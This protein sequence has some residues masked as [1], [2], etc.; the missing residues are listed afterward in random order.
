MQRSETCY[1]ENAVRKKGRK[2]KMKTK[3]CRQLTWGKQVA[4]TSSQSL[5]LPKAIRTL[6]RSG[7]LGD[8]KLRAK[9]IFRTRP[10]EGSKG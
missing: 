5:T 7:I 2:K 1:P 10:E 8:W 6:T 3:L 4:L 9:F